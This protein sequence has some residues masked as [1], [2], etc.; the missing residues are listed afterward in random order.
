MATDRSY[1][2]NYPI[3]ARSDYQNQVSDFWRPNAIYDNQERVFRPNSPDADED[4]FVISNVPD[5]SVG[6]DNYRPRTFKD[7]YSKIDPD[8]FVVYPDVV[9]WYSY[10]SPARR[11]SAG[12]E[13]ENRIANPSFIKANERAQEAY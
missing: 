3:A 10:D 1:L 6:P 9:K 8:G 7:R 13:Q 4:G 12:I 2:K 5:W 11:R